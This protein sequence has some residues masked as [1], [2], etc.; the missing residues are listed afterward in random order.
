[1]PE[2]PFGSGKCVDAT[3]TV[4]LTGHF[5]A[6]CLG[7]GQFSSLVCST[8]VTIPVAGPSV[9]ASIEGGG[10]GLGTLVSLLKTLLVQGQR[11]RLWMSEPKWLAQPTRHCW[12]GFWY[13]LT[14]AQHREWQSP[15]AHEV[16]AILCEPLGK[17]RVV[18]QVKRRQLGEGR[19][20][21]GLTSAEA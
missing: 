5:R 12:L 18:L 4:T 10:S 16:Q 14:N 13:L 2:E 9:W 7:Q 20:F 6:H 15:G 19:L 17:K 3:V 8:R 1:M 11:P 21:G